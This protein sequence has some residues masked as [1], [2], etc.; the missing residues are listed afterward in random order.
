MPNC[1]PHAHNERPSL[2]HTHTHTGY[3]Q[4][5]LI[6][7][8]DSSQSF[9][10]NIIKNN[11]NFHL[12]STALKPAPDGSHIIAHQKKN[13]SPILTNHVIST[14]DEHAYAMLATLEEPI[15]T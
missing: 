12:A 11:H 10:T 15:R 3:L 5:A 8:F 2:S 6:N 1:S 14:E 4:I 13:N 7:D 9:L